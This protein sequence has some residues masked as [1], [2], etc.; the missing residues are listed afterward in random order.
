MAIVGVG[1]D[2]VDVTRFEAALR[3]T[4]GV[5]ARLFVAAEAS[6]P[7]ASLAA[8]FAAKEAAAKALGTGIS[9]GIGWREIEVQRSPGHRPTLHLSGRAAQWCTRMGGGRLSL[10]LTHSRTTAMAV[11]ILETE[12][13]PDRT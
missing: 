1:I 9:R 5:S 7:V 3:R 10:S 2:V 12:S 6:R 8:R 11:V 4:P 13:E